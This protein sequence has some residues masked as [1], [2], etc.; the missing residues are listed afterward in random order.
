MYK[1]K[2]RKNNKIKRKLRVR[3]KV[4]GSVDRPRLTVFRSNKYIYG[5]IIDD[6]KGNTLVAVSSET[7]NM[8]KGKKK[9]DAAFE[10]GKLIAEKAKKNKVKKV[11]FDRNGYRFHGRVK[12][13]VEGA[14]E[15]GLEV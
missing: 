4:F 3:K 12:S 1:V 15:G 11:V 9:V 8:H 14:R 13:F 10:V 2:L 7:K 5:Q 6:T